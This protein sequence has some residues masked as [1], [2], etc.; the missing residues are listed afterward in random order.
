M[1][2]LLEAGL[3]NCFKNM[4]ILQKKGTAC[5]TESCV[6]VPYILHFCFAS[7]SFSQRYY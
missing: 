7:L 4:P 5:N 2:I 6:W 3:S 1:Q